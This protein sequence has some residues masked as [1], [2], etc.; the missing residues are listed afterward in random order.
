MKADIV[1]KLRTAELQE[2][3][4]SWK[5]YLQGSHHARVCRLLA[6]DLPDATN[7]IKN[8]MKDNCEKAVWGMG[9]TH[10]IGNARLR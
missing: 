1:D 5:Q 9:S 8:W 7:Q 6:S 3:F 10:A 4:A 2:Q